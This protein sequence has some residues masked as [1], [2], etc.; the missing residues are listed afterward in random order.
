MVLSVSVWLNT[1]CVYFPKCR[2]K[3]QKISLLSLSVSLSHSLTLSG[4]CL[5]VCMYVCSLIDGLCARHTDH[6]SP[7]SQTVTDGTSIGAL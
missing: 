2:T 5:S 1:S 4:L 7:S 6:P 3:L